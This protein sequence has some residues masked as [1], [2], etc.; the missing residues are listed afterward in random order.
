MGDAGGPR[1][2]AG[3]RGQPSPG[4]LGDSAGTRLPLHEGPCGPG[5]SP[6]GPGGLSFGGKGGLNLIL[7]PRKLWDPS[8]GGD[9]ELGF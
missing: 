1:C 5:M 3:K 4:A 2:S 9:G 7:V 6:E 8:L